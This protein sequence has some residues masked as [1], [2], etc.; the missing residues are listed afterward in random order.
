MYKFIA[1]SIFLTLT[2]WLYTTNHAIPI[3]TPQ[4]SQNITKLNFD[5]LIKD[6][7]IDISDINFDH[8]NNIISFTYFDN[9]KATKVILSDQKNIWLQLNALQ[10]INKMVKIKDRSLQLVDLSLRHPYA[11][12]KNN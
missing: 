7:Q 4:S 9:D 12:I 2:V 3:T 10:K 1:L 5:K 11:T 8:F 6:K